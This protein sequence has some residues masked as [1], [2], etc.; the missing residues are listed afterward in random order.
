MSAMNVEPQTSYGANQGTILALGVDVAVVRA[1]LL[2]NIGGHYRLAAWQH[3]P[4]R[5]EVSVADQCAALLR[6]LSD[7][8]GRP[9]LDRARGTPWLSAQ[10][11]IRRPPLAQV[12]VTAS[13]RAAVRV[14]LAGLTPRASIEAARQVLGNCPAQVVGVTRYAA[15]LTVGALLD[16]LAIRKPDMIV[17]V[18][19]YDD[20]ASGSMD[21]GGDGEMQPLLDLCRT[22]GQALAR[23][24][25]AHQPG[26]VFAGSRRAAAQAVT[27]LQGNHGGAVEQVENV[28]PAPDIIQHAGLAQAVNSYFAR[29]CRRADGMRELGRW[30]TSPGRLLA[31]EA[32]FSRLVRTWAEVQQL[33][34]LH[35]LYTGPTWWLHVWVRQ[36]QSSAR[37]RYVEAGSRPAEFGGWP[38]LQLVS[39][40]WPEDLWPQPSRFWWDRSGMAPMIAAVGQVAPL[41]MVQ[42]LQTD[43]LPLMRERM[44]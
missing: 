32:A 1:A 31:Q 18:G 35:G 28:H 6:T 12:T 29:L 36:G 44:R 20:G 2:E 43:L 26:V 40:R 24:A 38:P 37:L 16:D 23:T 27:A 10:D 5:A 19:G 39:G 42:V 21:D 30:V 33:S 8:Q 25:P 17:V 9:L 4:Y 34:E 7:Q 22:V 13:P 11:P 3:Q 14:W 15:E 41:A